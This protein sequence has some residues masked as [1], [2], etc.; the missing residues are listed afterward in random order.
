VPYGLIYIL[1]Q[2]KLIRLRNML[3]IPQSTL[4]LSKYLSYLAHSLI[5]SVFIFVGRFK[6]L[7]KHAGVLVSSL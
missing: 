6:Q 5:A 2:V 4:E 7:G 1:L 3:K